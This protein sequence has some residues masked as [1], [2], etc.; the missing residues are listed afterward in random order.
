MRQP[1]GVEMGGQNNFDLVKLDMHRKPDQTARQHLG[2]FVHRIFV[3]RRRIA[4]DLHGRGDVNHL[5]RYAL[6]DH[7]LGGLGTGG[8]DLIKGHQ[9]CARQS[10][11]PT[12]CAGLNAD[13]IRI[14][15]NQGYPGLLR[16]ADGIGQEVPSGPEAKGRLPMRQ[17]GAHIAACVAGKRHRP[18]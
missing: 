5:G 8:E 6:A 15:E 3:D 10:G 2:H 17:E 14:G 7:P 4:G 12:A 13:F 18:I 11:D 16:H 1:R 9:C